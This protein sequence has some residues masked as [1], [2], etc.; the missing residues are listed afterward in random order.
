MN[1]WLLPSQMGYAFTR[2]R[3]GRFTFEVALEIVRAANYYQASDKI[4]NDL[5]K[6]LIV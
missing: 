6:H 4:P 3:A 2:D 5:L 1:G